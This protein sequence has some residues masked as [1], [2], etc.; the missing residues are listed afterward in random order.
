MQNDSGFFRLSRC[1]YVLVLFS[2]LIFSCKK[3][4]TVTEP[5]NTPPPDYTV[6]EVKVENYVNKSFITL[7]GREPSTAELGFYKQNLLVANFSMA[8]RK[9]FLQDVIKLPDYLTHTYTVFLAELLNNQDTTDISLMISV[10]GILLNDT[11]YAPFWS[12]IQEEQ[13]RLIDF[14]KFNNEW[15]VGNKRVD[16]LHRMMVDNYFYDQINMGSLNYVIS[17]FQHFLL[18]NPS[19]SEETSCVTMIDGQSALLFGQLGKSK[20]DFNDI[21][22]NSDD[23]FEGQVRKYFLRY[24]F[25]EPD[26]AEMIKYTKDLKTYKDF[27]K[28]QSDI[29]AENEFAGI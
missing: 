22:F 7:I 1:F 18:R 15:A 27:T 8:E 13:N 2:L 20:K 10:F 16:E 19:N 24:Y 3:Y 28:F 17:V 23:Y 11:T 29:L 9:E 5:N 14:Q 12:I 6:D 21:F 25:R 26:N 4:E